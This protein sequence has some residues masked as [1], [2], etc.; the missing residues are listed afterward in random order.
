VHAQD[1]EEEDDDE[2]D[3]EDEDEE[4]EEEGG[5]VAGPRSARKGVHRYPL[6]DRARHQVQPYVPGQTERARCAKAC[7]PARLLMCVRPCHGPVGDR[8]AL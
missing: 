3:D 4:E 5:G 6:R 1:G 8:F 7:L 2:D